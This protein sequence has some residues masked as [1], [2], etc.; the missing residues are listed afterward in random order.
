[1]KGWR[2]LHLVT[3]SW[4]QMLG[5]WTEGYTLCYHLF[6]YFHLRVHIF[7]LVRHS[8]GSNRLSI[9]I[10]SGLSWVI[11]L[12]LC[13]SCVG[14]QFVQRKWFI[15]LLFGSVPLHNIFCFS[16]SFSYY[17]NLHPIIAVSFA[18]LSTADVTFLLPRLKSFCL[19][20]LD[21]RLKLKPTRTHT[22]RETNQLPLLW[23][24]LHYPPP[25]RCVRR[26]KS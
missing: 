22:E 23:K 3:P 16:R 5:K 10:N 12:G 25:P 19:I 1:M 17:L 14:L 20:L 11:C 7:F 2:Q 8:W 4:D 21:R 9:I 15:C 26:L 6:I 18:L 13:E 24:M